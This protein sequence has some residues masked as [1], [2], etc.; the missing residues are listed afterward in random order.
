MLIYKVNWLLIL[1]LEIEVTSCTCFIP[2][3]IHIPR[4]PDAC[5]QEPFRASLSST[6]FT[7]ASLSS[8]PS[9]YIYKPENSQDAPCSCFSSD[10]CAITSW[11]SMYSSWFTF[12]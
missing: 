6:R 4:S 5:E 7:F 11:Y 10:L 9:A 12:T 2:N 3:A 8:I 1:A